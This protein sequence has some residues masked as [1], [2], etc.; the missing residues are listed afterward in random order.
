MLKQRIIQFLREHK[1]VLLTAGMFILAKIL[2]IDIPFIL[3]G[4]S[5]VD[6]FDSYSDGDL[7][8]QGSWSGST[9]FDVQTTIKHS[10]TKAIKCTED[11][12]P[13]INI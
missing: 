9:A 12:I 1:G 6:N 11:G 13:T 10:G 7:N 4:L 3:F 5:L 2:D 8:G